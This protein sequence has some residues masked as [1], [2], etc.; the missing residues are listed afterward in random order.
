MRPKFSQACLLVLLLFPAGTHRVVAAEGYDNCTGFIDSLPATITTQGTWCLNKNLATA[1]TSG[2]AI[3]IDANN[4]T[5]DC[6][7]FKVGGLAGGDSTIAY[8]IRADDRRNATVRQ[9]NV[10]GFY[11]GIALLGGG[12]HVVEDNRLDNN[13]YMG[14]AISGENNLARRNLVNNTGGQAGGSFSCGIYAYADIMDNTVSGLFAD[15]PGGDLYG[16]WALGSG[17]QLRGNRISGFDMTAAQDNGAVA[18]AYGILLDGSYQRA[19]GNH[20]SGDATTPVNGIGIYA[21]GS[22]SYCLA[23]TLGGF[24][25]AIHTNCI[26]SGN[27]LAP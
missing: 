14:I 4:V 5:I 1:I 9:C 16:I 20:V 3:T 26:A 2:V 17:A 24:N 18:N 19:S 22:S 25:T 21:D 10:R 6:N 8:G 15:L 7:D 11:Y 23:N 12:G 13:L 27:L